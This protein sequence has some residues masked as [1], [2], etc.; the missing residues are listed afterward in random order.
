MQAVITDCLLK[1]VLCCCYSDPLQ[2]FVSFMGNKYAD[3]ESQVSAFTKAAFTLHTSQK[4]M[5]LQIV[6]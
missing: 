5:R 3:K 2:P 1:M 4:T 6:I